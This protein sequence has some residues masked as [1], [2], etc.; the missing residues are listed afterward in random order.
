MKVERDTV[1]VQDLPIGITIRP[2]VFGFDELTVTKITHN[3]RAGWVKIKG[4]DTKTGETVQL[5]FAD[6][7]SI[8]IEML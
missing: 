6:N 1:L 2:G 5:L 4:I 3:R 8:F 7:L